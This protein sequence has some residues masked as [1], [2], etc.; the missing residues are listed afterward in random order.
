MVEPQSFIFKGCIVYNLDDLIQ[1][2]QAYF[3][4]CLKR[5]REVLIKKNISSED[6]FYAKITKEGWKES[7]ASYCRAKILIKS[8]WVKS[9]VTKF[10]DTSVGVCEKVLREAPPILELEDCEKFCDDTGNVFEVEVRGV[11]EDKIYFKAIDIEKLFEME[12][13]VKNCFKNL[14]YNDYVNFIVQNKKPQRISFLTIEGIKKIICR[15]RSIS[16]FKL[17]LFFNNLFIKKQN[18]VIDIILL[19][20]EQET[21]NIIVDV[22]E[23]YETIK[24]FCVG[25]YKIDL[26]FPEYKLAIECDEFDHKDRSFDY[27][28]NREEYIKKKLKCT[29]LR[30]NPNEKFFKLGFILKLIFDYIHENTCIKYQ[31]MLLQEKDARIAELNREING[32]TQREKE[33]K[34]KK[35]EW[36]HLESKFLNREQEL[37]TQNTLLFKQLSINK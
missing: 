29:F 9:N 19:Y 13:L 6:Y 17:K 33:W 22:F 25:K 30:F 7:I 8:E 36:K 5:K 31:K 32:Y 3:Y 4:G 34:I 10:I 20:K 23:A 35:K 1:F 14:S 15:S 37:M 2:D 27:E 24:Q 16:P 18:I 21:I 26:Y 28:Y 11:R 12:N